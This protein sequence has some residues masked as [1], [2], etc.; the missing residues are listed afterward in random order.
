MSSW[1]NASVGYGD[2]VTSGNL[3]V[4]GDLKSKDVIVN[5]F[6]QINNASDGSSEVINYLNQNGAD[7]AQDYLVRATWNATTAYPQGSWVVDAT[8]NSWVKVSAGSST[9]GTAPAPTDWALKANGT[10]LSASTITKD[11]LAVAG[12]GP[13]LYLNSNP[14]GVGVQSKWNDNGGNSGAV[15]PIPPFSSHSTQVTD[16]LTVYGNNVIEPTSL[17][18]DCVLSLSVQSIVPGNPRTSYTF[19]NGAGNPGGGAPPNCLSLYAY[20]NIGSVSQLLNSTPMIDYTGDNY[21]S[22]FT[23]PALL[24][25]VGPQQSGRV[26]LP[27][28][29]PSVAVT[30][31]PAIQGT[32]LVVA[33][34]EG[35][36]PFPIS[37]AINPGA[38][39]TIY[40]TP[41]GIE[42]VAWFIVRI[43]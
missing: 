12:G 26:S 10:S 28:G 30:G 36:V 37:V 7:Q 23:N 17:G 27:A 35:T 8:G 22:S 25:F 39:F 29:G 1:I 21:G 3:T 20:G 16:A 31:F 42:S 14:Q 6:V 5:N 9:P 38:G 32:G 2:I 24:N 19:Y 33:V 40:G 41:A 15:P 11:A 4:T 18:K 13:V 43:A 34:A